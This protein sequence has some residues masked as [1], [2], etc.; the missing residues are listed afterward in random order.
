[1][2]HALLEQRIARW[3]AEAPAVAAHVVSFL[4]RFLPAVAADVEQALAKG[5]R[6]RIVIDM[7]AGAVSRF[8][9]RLLRSEMDD[10]CNRTVYSWGPPKKD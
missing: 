10:F 5:G 8:R 6:L 9:V 4:R 1:V 3:L 2:I 7:E